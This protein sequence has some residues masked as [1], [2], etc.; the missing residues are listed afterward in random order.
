LYKKRPSIQES[1]GASICFFGIFFIYL[2]QAQTQDFSNLFGNSLAILCGVQTAVYTLLYRKFDEQ[3]RA[4]HPYGVGVMTFAFGSIFFFILWFLNQETTDVA[5]SFTQIIQLHGPRLLLIGAVTMAIPSV[6]FA[7]V[8]KTL[9]P[10]LASSFTLLNPIVAGILGYIFLQE[11]LG[12]EVFLGGFLI[13]LGMTLLSYTL[14]WKR[15]EKKACCASKPS[16]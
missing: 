13:L 10:A 7:F 2:G 6:C 14:K 16:P 4:P 9:S 8:A 12:S 1:L 15:S 11:R 3:G 5:L